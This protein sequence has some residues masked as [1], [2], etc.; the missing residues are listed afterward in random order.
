M[1]RESR[2]DASMT[3]TTTA[4]DGVDR[5]ITH[6]ELHAIALVLA[7]SASLDARMDAIDHIV[8]GRITPTHTRLMRAMSDAWRKLTSSR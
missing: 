4:T 6:D 3:T 5:Q 8:Y 1:H 2:S 7:S